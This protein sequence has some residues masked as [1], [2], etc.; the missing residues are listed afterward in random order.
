MP[1]LGHDKIQAIPDNGKFGGFGVKATGS[2]LGAGNS[3]G[4]ASIGIIL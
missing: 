4:F 2:H 3:P 1:S